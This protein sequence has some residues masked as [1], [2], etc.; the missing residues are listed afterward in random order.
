MLHENLGQWIGA[1]RE[2]VVR[3]GDPMRCALLHF[4]SEHPEHMTS[5]DDAVR[6]QLEVLAQFVGSVLLRK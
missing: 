1:G 5:D 4:W 2:I 6:E 3:S